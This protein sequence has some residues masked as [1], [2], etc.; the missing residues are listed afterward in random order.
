MLGPSCPPE[1]GYCMDESI[2]DRNSGVYQ[3]NGENAN[4]R[5]MQE[6][7]LKLCRHHPGATGCEVIWDIGHRGCFAHTKKI[8]R[9]S[10]SDHH[11]CWVFSKCE[12]GLFK[13]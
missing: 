5:E 2:S 1:K 11:F 13:T 9:G 3:I 7:C 10:G 4:T 8:T 12:E 6:Q